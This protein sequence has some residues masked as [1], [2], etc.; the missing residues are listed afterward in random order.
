VEHGAFKFRYLDGK[1]M[2]TLSPDVLVEKRLNQEA[3]IT[4]KRINPL[5]AEILGPDSVEVWSPG[6]RHFQPLIEWLSD[7]VINFYEAYDVLRMIRE[8]NISGL[9]TLALTLLDDECGLSAPELD[10]RVLT[11]F[12][13]TGKTPRGGLPII[14][15]DGLAWVVGFE[16]FYKVSS[17]GRVYSFWRG[18]CKERKPIPGP[19]RYNQD[20][21]RVVLNKNGIKKT[22]SVHTLVARA[23]VPGYKPGLTVNHKNLVKQDNRA[24]N[25]E[26]VTNSENIKHAWANGAFD[27]RVKKQKNPAQTGI[28]MYVDGEL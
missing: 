13:A 1:E 17:D 24:E 9:E 23:F 2:T 12:K 26:W 21:L 22:C 5:Q 25:L 6:G 27:A 3:E 8:R 11:A 4:A 14:E 20:Y 16:G 15:P 28:P 7:K 18:K 19:T 10:K